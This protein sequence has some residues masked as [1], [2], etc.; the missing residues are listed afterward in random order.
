MVMSRKREQNSEGVVTNVNRSDTR[1][2][3]DNIDP[4]EEEEAFFDRFS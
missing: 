4:D 3:K 2:S 1:P